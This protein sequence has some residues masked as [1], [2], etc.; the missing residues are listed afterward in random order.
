MNATSDP[1]DRIFGFLDEI[2][3]ALAD[4]RATAAELKEPC[5]DDPRGGSGEGDSRRPD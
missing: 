3:A 5:G 1:V 4:L 2:D